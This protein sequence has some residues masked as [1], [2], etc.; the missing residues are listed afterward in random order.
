MYKKCTVQVLS[1]SLIDL[2][3][4]A[5]MAVGTSYQEQDLLHY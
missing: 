3:V 2:V 1:L 5:M 4:V